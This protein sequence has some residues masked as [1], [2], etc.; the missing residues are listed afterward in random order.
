MKFPGGIKESLTQ[1]RRELT[2]STQRLLGDTIGLSD[3]DWRGPS[4]LPGWSRAHVSAHL[5]YHGECLTRMAARLVET[6][7]SVT[8]NCSYA[9]DDLWV[10]A[11]RNSLALTEDLDESCAAVSKALDSITPAL[12]A[13]TVRT[14]HGELPA[15]A[16]VLNRINEVV[17][18]HVDMQ[19]GVDFTD[20]LPALVRLLL[21]WNVFRSTPRFSEVELTM[22]TDEGLTLTV[23]QGTPMTVRGSE[24]NLLGW[25]TGRKLSTAILGAEQ[26]DLRHPV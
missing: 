14:S 3:N 24:A 9:D 4:L 2:S 19:L 10:K 8:W 25:I 11:Q 12:W 1:W 21:Q 20:L 15:S 18:H 6:Q 13:R 23:G 17:V 26:L 5:A 16:M 7:E 22:I